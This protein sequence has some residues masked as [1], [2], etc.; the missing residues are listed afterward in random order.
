MVDI[1][2]LTGVGTHSEPKTSLGLPSSTELSAAMES[3]PPRVR[4]AL[5][6]WGISSVNFSLCKQ[7]F[8]RFFPV[9]Q[10]WV[11]Y[12]WPL[13]RGEQ[14]PPFGETIQVTDGRSWHTSKLHGL[15]KSKLAVFLCF[16]LVAGIA[17]VSGCQNFWAPRSLKRKRKRFQGPLNYDGL[18]GNVRMNPME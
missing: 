13:K 12:S 8:I 3:W 6:M 17:L 15:A 11:F 10:T 16:V 4:R 9:T 7:S 14:W 1:S 18:C 2:L 5:E